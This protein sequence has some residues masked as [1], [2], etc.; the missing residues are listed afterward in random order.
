MFVEE[1]R[2]ESKIGYFGGVARG[3]GHLGRMLG[4]YLTPFALVFPAVFWRARPR[5]PGGGDQARRLVGA[6]LAIELGLVV[7]GIV[8][9]SLTFLKF[10]WLMPAFCLV[11]LLAFAWLDRT[12]LDRGMLRRYALALVIAEVAVILG[13]SLNV[14]RGDAFGPSTRLNAPYDRVART[15]ADAGFSAGTIAAGD[16]PLAGNLRLRFPD[17]RVVRL[18]NPDFVPPRTGDGQCLVVWEEPLGQPAALLGWLRASLDAD[19]AGEPVRSVSVPFHHARALALRVGY[20]L[21]P[22]GRGTCR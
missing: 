20:V 3:L 14:L 12:A 22:A 18:T 13:L 7:L 4:I 11:P 5:G 8:A 1:V 15:L 21:L 10:R 2:P 17:S 9:G 6:L 16:G 19:V